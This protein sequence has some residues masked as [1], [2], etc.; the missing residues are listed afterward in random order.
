MQNFY[1]CYATVS[2]ETI[3]N[4]ILN[5]RRLLPN[6]TELMAVLKADAYGHG[7]AVVGKYIEPYI[8]SAG[9]ATVEEGIE[10]RQAGVN[11]P[12]LVLG[13]TSP[14]QFEIMIKNNI[15]P[16]IYNEQ[17]AILYSKAA[18]RLNLNAGY[19]IAV[20]TGMTRIGFR[21][22]DES[23][24]TIERIT[25]LDNIIFKG[26]FTHLSC[27]DTFDEDYTAKQ[28]EEY[29]SMCQ[30]LKDRKIKLPMRHVCNSAGIMKYPQKYYEGVRSGIITYGMY[31]SNE[32]DKKLLDIKP[33]LEWKAHIINIS[34]VEPKRGVS[35]GATY[36]TEK[37]IT[38]IA[39][40]GVGYADGY[41]RSLSSKGCVLIHGKRAPIIGRV[42]MDQMMVDVTDIPDVKLED[43]ATLIGRDGDEFISIEELS[44][45]AGSFNYEMSCGIGK[46]VKRIYL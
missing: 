15:M 23:A 44:N 25:K 9:V 24:D 8:D 30:K 2:L 4:N 17:I 26:L 42:C 35:Y 21:V 46:R 27:A 22:S 43:I 37:S 40:I 33:A 14:K 29:D 39:T 3:K 6:N 16:T 45:K 31:P 34:N 11:V 10:L 5:I 38:K 1:R 36:I 18:K 28:F 41:P 7:A 20:D 12:I 19:D 32:V 13:Y